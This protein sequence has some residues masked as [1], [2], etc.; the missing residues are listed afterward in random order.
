MNLKIKKQLPKIVLA[1]S[2]ACTAILA[3]GLYN[4][5]AAYADGNVTNRN[6][7]V[8][9]GNKQNISHKTEILCQRILEIKDLDVQKLEIEQKH[10][11]E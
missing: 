4:K 2:L 8:H 11:T 5:N 1:Q 3:N 6:T 10:L 7:G 9:Q